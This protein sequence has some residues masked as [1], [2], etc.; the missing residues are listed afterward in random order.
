M[1]LP[2]RYGGMGIANP[3]EVAN[4]EY[5]ASKAITQNLANIILQQEQD[6]SM[7]NPVNTLEVIKE[8]NKA[9]EFNLKE[10]LSQIMTKHEGTPMK[11]CLELNMEMGA[12]S[13]L[14]ALPLQDLG[15][16]LNKQEFRDAVCLRFGW[17]IPNTPQF[18]GCGDKNNVDH[19]LICRK[20]GYVFMRHNALRDLNAELQQEV[21][22]DVVVEPNLLLLESETTIDGTTADRARPDISSRGIWST[23]ERTFFDVCVLHPNSPSYQSTSITSLY[24]KHEK[25]KMQKYG[26]RILTVEKGSFT[27][28]IYT[29]TGGWGPQAT[30]YL[31]RIS[32]LIANKRNEDYHHVIS[33]IRTR[34]RFALLKSVLVAVRGERGRKREAAQAVSLVSFN[35]IPNAMHYESP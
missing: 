12:G 26:Q 3:V 7:Y 25:K 15:Y 19:T 5:L 2:V 21:C 6:I 32:T 1:A 22:K 14:T 8:V 17:K 33:H 13:W 24:D 27:P 23:F 28:L 11:R 10:K 9:K 34:V 29:T 31:K 4:R 18:C 16:C 35:M 30:A 20:G